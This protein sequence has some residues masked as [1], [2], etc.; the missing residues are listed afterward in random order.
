MNMLHIMFYD[1]QGKPVRSALRRCTSEAAHDYGKTIVR[2][3]PIVASYRIYW[4][5]TEAMD[6]MGYED[7]TDDAPPFDV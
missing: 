7:I 3:A 4:T 1:N 2:D 6:L 5:K